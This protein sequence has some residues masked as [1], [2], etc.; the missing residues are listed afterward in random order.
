MK[1]QSQDSTTLDIP[2]YKTYIICYKKWKHAII[3]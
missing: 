1:L 3:F 2:K